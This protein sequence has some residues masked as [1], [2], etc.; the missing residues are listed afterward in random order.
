MELRTDSGPRYLG[1]GGGLES[2]RLRSRIDLNVLVVRRSRLTELGGFDE[3][4]R[5][6]G[7]HDLVIRLAQREEPRFLPFIGCRRETSPEGDADTGP[8]DED[9]WQF[10]VIGKH[11][12]DW[13]ALQ[14]SPAEAAPG[15]VS[16]VVPTYQDQAMTAVAVDSVLQMPGDLEVIVVDNG[17]AVETGVVLAQLWAG[18]PRVRVLHLPRNLNFGIGSNLG[19][20]A[21]TGEFVFFLNNDTLAPA[22]GI[23][24]LVDRLS[25][26][27]CLGVQPL[28]LYGDDSIQAAGVIFLANNHLPVS[29]LA[30]MPPEDARN[31]GDL[32]FSVVTAA[33]LLMRRADVVRLRG[34]DPRFVNGM[35]DID[36]CLRAG[37]QV[38]GGYFAV[39]PGVRFQHL[40][41]KTP[42]RGR[43]LDGN[44]RLLMERWW[45]RLPAPEHDKLAAANLRV[46]RIP[47]DGR[48]IPVLRPLYVRDRESP[49]LRWGVRYAS[50]GGPRGDRWGDT[51][52]AESLTAALRR[53][54][55][56][57]VT[58]RHG[59]NA[60][61]AHVLDDVNLVL[62]G[63]DRVPPIP[64]LVN[65][66]WVI[67]H[68]ELLTPL[69]V[70]GYDVVFA[71][72]TSWSEQFSRR[73]GREVRPLL[74]ATDTTRFA[75]RAPGEPL[76]RPAVFVGGNYS[77]RERRVVRDAVEAGVDLRVI[78][79][80][81][82]GSI[83][84]PLIEAEHVDNA[85]LSEVYRGASRVLADHWPEMAE[86]GFIQN[87]LFDAVA[88]G[89]R[90]ISDDVVG[91]REVFGSAVQTYSSLDEL[92]HLCSPE[93][94]ARFGTDEEIQRQAEEVRAQHSFD[95]RARTLVEA[96]ESLRQAN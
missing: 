23:D 76:T 30:G 73:A 38:P 57:V 43:H 65:V 81:W 60:D 28:L 87:R 83:P 82:D 71:A 21:A 48:L 29:H 36:L 90:V 15:R 32:R 89:A 68:P 70:R 53:T 12:V 72:S 95:V 92:R 31:V 66:L 20:V 86:L 33:A 2:L 8:T 11:L 17:S 14:A 55:Q 85:E 63:L 39:E 51:S 52:Y 88:S 5:G 27:Q 42:G 45:D 25:D 49:A 93:G 64:G 3:E 47:T 9:N 54:G 1:R 22:A 35:E 78:G 96:V 34:F 10:A 41:S 69:E 24:R 84:S 37:Q 26:P 79:S 67:S 40:E 19:A 62:R 59:A 91:L 56:E 16:V 77:R 94:A 61:T 74:Q 58:Y 44:R 75:S 50:N 6:A 4:L 18:E 80:G 13:G 46:A 7:D